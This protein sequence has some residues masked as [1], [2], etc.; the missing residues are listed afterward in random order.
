LV[1]KSG[2]GLSGTTTFPD[3]STY[4]TT[5]TRTAAAFDV[6]IAT[7]PPVPTGTVT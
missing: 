1:L 3:L 6:E 5:S 4:P 2:R 7:R